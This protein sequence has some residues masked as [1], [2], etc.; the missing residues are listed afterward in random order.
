MLSRPVT[1]VEVERSI[2]RYDYNDFFQTVLR[3]VPHAHRL[4]EHRVPS[5]R[6]AANHYQAVQTWCGSAATFIPV[7]FVGLL[8]EGNIPAG[9]AGSA[10]TLAF[11]N[12]RGSIISRPGDAGDNNNNRC[13][14]RQ[15]L[16]EAHQA[17]WTADGGFRSTRD[18]ITLPVVSP[19]GMNFA[20]GFPP[21]TLFWTKENPEFLCG[22][23]QRQSQ[24]YFDQCRPPITRHTTCRW[25]LPAAMA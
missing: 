2:I 21:R 12:G 11:G 4:L 16:L 3:A 10:T 14:G 7:H 23:R 20:N 6:L 15:S 5:R 18:K 25:G 9:G 17:L 24:E 19:A 13:L 22:I 8:A 1:H